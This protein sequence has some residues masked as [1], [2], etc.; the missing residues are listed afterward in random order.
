MGDFTKLRWENFQTN[1]SKIMQ[2]THGRL[3][4][5]DG[6][7]PNSALKWWSE[8]LGDYQPEHL[9]AACAWWRNTDKWGKWP[10]TPAVVH[11][12]M[13]EMGY[14]KMDRQAVLTG[15]TVD[16]YAPWRSKYRRV[17]DAYVMNIPEG[18]PFLISSTRQSV[19]IRTI[20]AYRKEKALDAKTHYGD[21]GAMM[22]RDGILESRVR[23]AF[24]AEHDDA[25]RRHNGGGTTSDRFT[26]GG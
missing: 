24:E 2:A 20:E 17:Y 16:P 8:E 10:K 12:Y 4:A 18:M 19:F 13:H 25:E 14:K 1:F 7:D 6:A 22:V 15:P 23:R 26:S 21:V 3:L 11:A 5:A 9:Q